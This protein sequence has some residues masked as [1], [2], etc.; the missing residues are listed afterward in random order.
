M[1]TRP[2]LFAVILA[3]ILFVMIF[4]SPSTNIIQNVS[5]LKNVAE[6]TSARVAGTSITNGSFITLPQG[7]TTSLLTFEFRGFD[8]DNH[9][10][11]LRCSFDGVT[12]LKN[13]CASQSAETQSVFAGPDGVQR[14]YYVR[15]GTAYLQITPSLLFK[16]HT[17]GVKVLSDNSNLS[18]P[19]TWLVKIRA[20]PDIGVPNNSSTVTENNTKRVRVFFE[21]IAVYN[22]HDGEGIDIR[23]MTCCSGEWTLL[24]FVQGKMIKL[25]DH[26]VDGGHSYTLHKDITID[27]RRDL[28]L[29]IFTYGVDDDSFLGLCEVNELGLGYQAPNIFTFPSML[30]KQKIIDFVS[31]DGGSCG[32]SGD[33]LGIINE[34]YEPQGHGEGFH[35]VKSSSG[36]FR[37]K[38]VVIP[39]NP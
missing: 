18:P 12:Y 1:K 4:L 32:D 26:N 23:P 14:N 30:W 25:L 36:D 21:S 13:N 39:V 31:Q 20:A 33:N 16:T 27:I 10:V 19:A 7:T 15:T 9:I 8:D 24:A 28:P 38:F 5:A 22:D 3:A 2:I 37:L 29:S 34:L 35:Q 17:F 6:I 11:E